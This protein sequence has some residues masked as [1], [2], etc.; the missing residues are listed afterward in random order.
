ML[1]SHWVQ[2]ISWAW[3]LSS[4][5]MTCAQSLCHGSATQPSHVLRSD[6][7]SG[8]IVSLGSNYHLLFFA[9]F[10]F[11]LS[12]TRIDP[13]LNPPQRSVYDSSLNFMLFSLPMVKLLQKYNNTWWN[14]AW[15]MKPL[16]VNLRIYI[17][18][19]FLGKNFKSTDITKIK[20]NLLPM[21]SEEVY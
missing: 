14:V 6:G 10:R 15:D 19:N 9:T 11:K 13:T 20:I 8:T 2:A 18:R 7:C 16:Y 12:V 5:R 1:I 21:N 3:L 17:E 4:L